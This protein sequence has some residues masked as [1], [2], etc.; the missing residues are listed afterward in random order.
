MLKYET[1]NS[2]FYNLQPNLGLYRD[3]EKKWKTT[4]A[5]ASVFSDF[6][7]YRNVLEYNKH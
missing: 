2:Y 5:N 6:I 4:E 3:A 7:I 1:E